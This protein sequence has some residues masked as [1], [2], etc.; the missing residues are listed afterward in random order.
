MNHMHIFDIHDGVCMYYRLHPAVLLP[1]NFWSTAIY[2][3]WGGKN[4]A[5]SHSRT[6][7]WQFV[8]CKSFHQFC[9][10]IAQLPHHF[11]SSSFSLISMTYHKQFQISQSCAPGLCGELCS[12]IHE[13][14]RHDGCRSDRFV[15]R[16]DRSSYDTYDIPHLNFVSTF[17]H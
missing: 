17:L 13:W 6:F 15:M 8:A 3:L 7:G 2:A 11:L 16:T 5:Q 4:F 1:L 10:M 9:V 14:I 12:W